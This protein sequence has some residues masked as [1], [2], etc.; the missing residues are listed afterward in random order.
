MYGMMDGVPGRM[1]K[2]SNRR[3]VRGGR[4]RIAY[5]SYFELHKGFIENRHIRAKVSW[6]EGS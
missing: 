6:G 2:I 5:W 4:L 3:C 1:Y